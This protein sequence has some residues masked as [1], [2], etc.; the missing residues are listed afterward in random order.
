MNAPLNK[1]TETGAELTGA[2]A[3]DVGVDADRISDGVNKATAIP[4][5]F[6]ATIT[7]MERATGIPATMAGET[8]SL[9]ATMV[10]NAA[11]RIE[12]AT[13]DGGTTVT[14]TST[15]VATDD[16]P[17]CCIIAR[18]SSTQPRPTRGWL[19]L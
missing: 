19:V 16:K 18:E 8:G 17:A 4:H 7:V 5:A 13:R 6:V 10:E 9:V 3:V 12:M 1:A 2:E 11:G 15:G 14:G